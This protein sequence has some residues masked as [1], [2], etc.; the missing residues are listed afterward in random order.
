MINNQ[1]INLDYL[2][3]I[4]LGNVE[5][6]KE[7]LQTFVNKTPQS[8]LQM[9]QAFQTEDFEQVGKIAHQLKTSFSFVGME[10]MVELCKRIQDMGLKNMDIHLLPES[11]IILKNNLHLGLKEIENELNTL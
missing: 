5:F 8:L 4:A 7:M 1:Y 2:N 3:E 10:A 6:K 9:E 11:L